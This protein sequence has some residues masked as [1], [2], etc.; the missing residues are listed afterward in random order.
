MTSSQLGRTRGLALIDFSDDDD[1][2][3]QAA[4]LQY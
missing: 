4:E 2:V 1:D 3:E